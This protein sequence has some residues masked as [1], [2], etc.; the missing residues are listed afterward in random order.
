VP[1]YIYPWQIDYTETSS[2]SGVILEENRIIT[3]AHVIDN[4][5]SIY[6]RKTGSD[7]RYKAK[8]EYISDAS[9]LAIISVDNDEFFNDT[10]PLLL[11]QASK[12]GDVVTTWGFPIGGSQLTIT[13]GIIS[14]I[15]Y[16]K[17]SHSGFYNLVG[18]IDA[19]INSGASGGPAIV[20][21]KLAGITFQ[22]DDSEG[23]SNIGYIIPV[24]VISQFLNDISDKE[25]DGVPTIAINTQTMNNPQI[26]EAFHMKADMSG[27]LVKESSPGLEE[28]QGLIKTGDVLLEIDGLTVGNDGTVPYITGDRIDLRYL[29]TRKQLGES[30]SIRLLRNGKEQSFNYKFNY[31]NYQSM[32]VTRHYSGFIPD[33]EV[34]GGLVFQELS[35]D[36]ILNNFEKDEYPAWM[37]TIYYDHK[38]KE[39]SIKD[40]AVFLATI[41]PDEINLGYDDYEDKQVTNVNGTNIDSLNEFRQAI[42]NNNSEFHIIKFENPSGQ[43]ILNKQLTNEKEA[44]FID[45]YNIDT[46][47]GIGL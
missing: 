23:A 21:G 29:F 15:D 10:K 45:R 14:R 42:K 35:R 17:Y 11:G 19:A 33:Y 16:D 38:E 9:D 36:Y 5:L 46:S 25:V 6:V 41:L 47:T 31:N 2:G 39:L 43:I 18:Q 44:Y 13:K 1:D 22:A 28:K 34:I 27:V 7:K 12:L 26:R 20:N 37:V 3:A 24:A 4:S 32:L 40:K 30:I 8:I